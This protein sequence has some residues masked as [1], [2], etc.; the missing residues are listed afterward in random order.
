MKA[1]ADL[2]P[3]MT[4]CNPIVADDTPLTMAVTSIDGVGFNG[5]G[6]STIGAAIGYGDC[7]PCTVAELS[8]AAGMADGER[9]GHSG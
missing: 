5:D 2:D 4:H 3:T 8:T 7:E 9:S 6:A 1:V